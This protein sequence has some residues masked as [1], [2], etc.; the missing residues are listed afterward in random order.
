MGCSAVLWRPVPSVGVQAPVREP[1][2]GLLACQLQQPQIALQIVRAQLCSRL[3]LH[4]ESALSTGR[5]STS[6][7]IGSTFFGVEER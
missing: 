1:L 4:L 3:G 6:Y 5:L 7:G 2:Q